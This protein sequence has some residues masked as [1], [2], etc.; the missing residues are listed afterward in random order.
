[1]TGQLQGAVEPVRAQYCPG[2]QGVQMEAPGAPEYVPTI[3]GVHCVALLKE[4]YP[5]GQTWGVTAF[6]VHELPEGHAAHAVMPHWL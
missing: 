1:M 6:D 2:L 5:G 3:H 4:E